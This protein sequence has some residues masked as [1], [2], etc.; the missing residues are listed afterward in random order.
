MRSYATAAPT[1]V[2]AP[3]RPTSLPQVVRPKQKD[4]GHQGWWW[5]LAGIIG[6]AVA[7]LGYR[8]STSP[9]QKKAATAPLRTGVARR[10]AL[11]KTIRL[12]GVTVAQNAATLL[13]PRMW[14]VR[15]HGS[16]N[17]DFAQVLQKL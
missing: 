11:A 10:G 5:L 7:I 16:S 1:P 9:A 14:G 8:F 4:P 15:I 17:N 12:T 13:T 3:Q 2:R 6:M